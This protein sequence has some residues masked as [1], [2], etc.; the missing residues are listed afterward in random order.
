MEG[1]IASGDIEVKKMK[2]NEVFVFGSNEA[3]K[4]KKFAAKTALSVGA[5]M[6]QA[7]GLQGRSFGIPTKDKQVKNPLPLNRIAQYVERFIDFAI[8]N[9]QLTFLVTEIGCGASKYKPKDIAPMFERAIDVQN[10][11]LPARFWHKLI[12]KNNEPEFT[13]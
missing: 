11:H 9:P 10:I 6:G 2:P 5:K 12:V 3:G 13:A 4:H 7:Y 1:R 8:A